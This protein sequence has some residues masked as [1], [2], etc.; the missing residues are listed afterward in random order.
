MPR[1]FLALEVD[2]YVVVY[3]SCINIRMNRGMRLKVINF[4]GGAGIGKSTI[5]AEA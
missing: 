5:A 4:Y 1:A 3:N 2:R